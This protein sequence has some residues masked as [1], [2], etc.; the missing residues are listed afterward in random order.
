M[1]RKTQR[2]PQALCV[3]KGLCCSVIALGAGSLTGAGVMAQTAGAPT[4]PATSSAF[5]SVVVF[6][7]SL[8]DPG[9]LAYF[10]NTTG[11][12]ALPTGTSYTTNPDPVWADILM[13]TF[14]IAGDYRFVGGGSNYAYGGSCVLAATDP[15]APDSQDYQAGCSGVMPPSIKQQLDTYLGGRDGQADPDILYVIW[16]G[17]NDIDAL[18]KPLLA[19]TSLFTPQGAAQLPQLIAGMGNDIKKVAVATG[20]QI[21]RLQ[22]AGAE[23]I[24]VLNLPDLSKTPF[25]QKLNNSQLSAVAKQFIDIHNS[26]LAQQIELRP[27]GIVPVN[28]YGLMDEVFANPQAYGFTKVA[29]QAGQLPFA[30]GTFG[31]NPTKPRGGSESLVCGHPGSGYPV[32]VNPGEQYFWADSAHGTGAA[33]QIVANAAIATLDAPVQISLAAEGGLAIATAHREAIAS[34]RQLRA[35]STA[36]PATG[37]NGYARGNIGS[38][39]LKPG[40]VLRLG[41]TKANLRVLTLGADYVNSGPFDWG[42]ALSV[43]GHNNDL[44]GADLE[45]TGFL[46]SAYGTWHY[47]GLSLS[48]SLTAGRT[49]VDAQRSIQLG[50]LRRHHKGSTNVGQ[51]GADVEL[52]VFPRG[53]DNKQHQL[54]LGLGWLNQGV[55]GFSED[56]TLS[57][58]MTFADFD[59]DSL[60]ARIGY[61]LTGNLGTTIQGYGRIGFEKELLDDPVEVTA[62]SR[63]MPGRFTREGFTP[64]SQ[65][66]NTSVGVIASLNGNTEV[67]LGYTGRFGDQER[68]DHQLNLGLS[69]EF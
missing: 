19:H 49:S 48:G 1:L 11:K 35:S 68:E 61:Q 62:G 38:E 7:D 2:S 14:G 6:G 65:W 64:S 4:A 42:A 17:A 40:D 43:G 36:E 69:L 5:G 37:W 8:S 34:E 16:G 25:V 51:F 55:E 53:R 13:E 50:P 30:C 23:N 45:S 33:Q 32:T 21:R 60:I 56:G 66:L 9:N 26:T 20:N 63:T 15:G 10:L 47:Q 29:L 44:A 39:S 28:V 27:D 41:A 59:R 12:I 31:V 57:T 24:L 67:V 58:A 18:A 3:F 22:D 52:A 46:G 54:A